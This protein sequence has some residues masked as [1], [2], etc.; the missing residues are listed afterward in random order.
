MGLVCAHPGNAPVPWCGLSSCLGTAWGHEGWDPSLNPGQP[1]CVFQGISISYCPIPLPLP[2]NRLRHARAA[3]SDTR[4]RPSPW[5]FQQVPLVAARSLHRV[6]LEA[7]G[8]LR[9]D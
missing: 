5:P 3:A 2:A 4:H 8:P 9:G 6:P 1:S 7:F